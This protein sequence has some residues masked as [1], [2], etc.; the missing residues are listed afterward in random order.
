MSPAPLVPSS[1]SNLY[2]LLSSFVLERDSGIKAQS[3]FRFQ[4]CDV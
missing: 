2:P 1:S 4:P 3:S